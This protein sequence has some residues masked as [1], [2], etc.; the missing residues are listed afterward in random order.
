MPAA[1]VCFNGVWMESQ[2]HMSREMSEKE[3]VLKR[4]S[5]NTGLGQCKALIPRIVLAFLV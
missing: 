4:V 3:K 5:S 1:G 2:G